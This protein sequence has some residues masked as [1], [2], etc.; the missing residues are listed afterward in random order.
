MEKILVSKEIALIE[1]SHGHYE[2]LYTQIKIL[3]DA[4]YTV[5][6]ICDGRDAAR[7]KTFPGIDYVFSLDAQAQFKN[8]LLTRKYL[9]SHNIGTVVFNTLS[10][11]KVRNLVLG[12]PNRIKV[13]GIIHNIAKLHSSFSQKLIRRKI[14]SY[15]VL[16]DYLIDAIQQPLNVPVHAF[17]PIFFPEYKSVTIDKSQDEFWVC[18]PGG[19]EYKRRKYGVILSALQ[20]GLDARIKFVLLGKCN[21]SRGD[22]ADFLSKAAE[23]GE[24][25]RFITFEGF[26]EDELFFSYV[27]LSDVILPLMPSKRY[28]TKTISGTI[29]LAFG[30]RIPMVIED[31]FA[32]IEDF[33]SSSFFCSDAH[34][35][36]M[37]NELCESREAL[38]EKREAISANEKFSFDYQKQHYLDV[39]ER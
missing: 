4:G 28:L 27:K 13:F 19:I 3:K 12:M 6:L 24:R 16:N 38:T 15:F 5:H 8:I 11:T 25:E 14:R 32:S 17:Y 26:I 29:N 31:V 20:K 21:P 2:C 7:A 1:L 39:I 10:G 23:M 34:L 33:R 30:Y 36:T 35:S 37:L 9:K 22:A 18:I